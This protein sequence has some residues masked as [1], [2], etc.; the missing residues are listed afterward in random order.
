V[1]DTAKDNGLC[2]C[3]RR[4]DNS[5]PFDQYIAAAIATLET[6]K[7]VL[8]ALNEMPDAVEGEVTYPRTVILQFASS[9][10]FYAEYNAPEYTTARQRRK[11]ASTGP[12]ILMQGLE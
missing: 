3:P 10:A 9:T 12:F 11:A 8:L 7:A 2:H 1:K 4:V 6:H 5:E